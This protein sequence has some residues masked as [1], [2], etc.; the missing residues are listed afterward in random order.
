MS[1]IQN[2]LIKTK[3]IKAALQKFIA[4]HLIPPSEA[5][6][7]ITGVDTLLKSS[8]SESFKH[9]PK[10]QLKS[11]F[12]KERILKEEISFTQIYAVTLIHRPKKDLE[13]LYDIEYGKFSTHPKLILSPES[14]IPYKQYKPT[15]LLNILYKEINKIKAY[16]GI[17]IS[18]FDESLKKALKTLIKYIYAKKFIKK[19]KIPLFE[20]IEPVVARDAKLIFWFKEKE[21]EGVVVEVAADEVLVEY[22]KPIFGKSGLNAFGEYIHAQNAKGMNDLDAKVDTQSIYIEEDTHSKRY[23]AKQKGYVYYDG[24]VLAVDNKLRLNEVSRNRSILNSQEEQNNIE[25]HIKQHDITK[26]SIGEGV[27][28]SSENIH[29]DGF[30]GAKS[31][32]EA[33]S[34]EIEGATHQDSKQFAKYAKINRHKGTLRCHEAHIKLLE[35]GSIHAT[36]AIVETSMSGFIYAED[37]IIKQVK[38]NLKVYATNSITIEVVSGE[39]NHFEINY[40]KVPIILSK[41]DY[42]KKDIEELRYKRKQAE[43]FHPEKLAQITQKIKEYKAEIEAI[44]NCYL[45][46]K[47]DIKHPLKGL[48][49]ICF[50]IDKENQLL[51]KTEAKRYETFYIE[52]EDNT[53]ILQPPALSLI[54]PAE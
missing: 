25:L 52:K 12:N 3:K 29:V 26:D 17:L 23:K 43:R 27:S 40:Q 44:K 35:G 36:K 21:Q 16:N 20:G 15:E 46:A 1:K 41:I 7:Q 6:F 50:T 47:V 53:L 37:V 48:N 38:S 22:K 24:K 14:K 4:Q 28:L 34:L 51:Y 32:L 5:D 31:L 2:E 30:V 8:D 54:L 13:L 19:V 49:I 10:D 45:S 39:D 18:I 42:I 33:H 11:Y 9:Y